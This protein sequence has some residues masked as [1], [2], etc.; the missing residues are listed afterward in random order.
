M[1]RNIN[2]NMDLHTCL[3]RDMYDYMD[4]E[5]HMY[6]NTYLDTDFNMAR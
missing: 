3:N 5:M 2:M 4:R 6:L 1:C